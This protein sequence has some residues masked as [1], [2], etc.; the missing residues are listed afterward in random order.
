MKDKEDYV[1][2]RIYTDGT[3]YDVTD[4]D[5]NALHRVD[6]E[7]YIEGMKQYLETLSD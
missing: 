5:H 3:I 6:V 7:N 1:D 4:G 2:T